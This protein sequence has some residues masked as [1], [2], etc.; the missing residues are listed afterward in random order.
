[1]DTVSEHMYDQKDELN[2][3]AQYK[4]TAMKEKKK[5]RAKFQQKS[6]LKFQRNII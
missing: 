5:I 3:C 4:K 2:F 1:M 6:S